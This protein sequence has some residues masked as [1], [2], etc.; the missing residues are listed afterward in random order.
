MTFAFGHSILAISHPFERSDLFTGT[1]YLA[2]EASTQVGSQ[3][4]TPKTTIAAV[5]SLAG[6]ALFAVVFLVII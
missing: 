6:L 2:R 3:T 1:G 5:A 4:L